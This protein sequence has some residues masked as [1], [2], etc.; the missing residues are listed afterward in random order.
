MTS[1]ALSIYRPPNQSINFF[2]DKLWEV[3]DI[4]SKHYKNICIFGDFNATLENNDTINFMNNNIC[5]S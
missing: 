3:L 4:Y 2:L 1:N 5:Q